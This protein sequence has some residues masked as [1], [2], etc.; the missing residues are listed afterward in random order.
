MEGES[1]KFRKRASKAATQA[2]RIVV[3]TTLSALIGKLIDAANDDAAIVA[4]VKR[5]FDC[6]EVRMGQGLAPVRLIGGPSRFPPKRRA[7]TDKVK[8]VWA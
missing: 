6:C 4:S 1:M 8:P 7:T 5:I 3:T 2:K